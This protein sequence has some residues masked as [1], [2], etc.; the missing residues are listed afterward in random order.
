MYDAVACV[1]KAPELM[2]QEIQSCVLG[3]S[4]L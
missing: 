4:D 1:S 2:I 3:F